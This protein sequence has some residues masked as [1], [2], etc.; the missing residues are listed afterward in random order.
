MGIPL[1]FNTIAKEYGD[2]V[3]NQ[4]PKN[5][6]GLYL[7]LNCAIHPCCRRVLDENYMPSNRL[8]YETKMLKEI[9]DYIIKLITITDPQLIFI[10]I[11][12]VAP[13]AK[14]KQQRSRRFKHVEPNT[15]DT[16]AISPGTP[17]MQKIK[18]SIDRL[19]SSHSIFND[20]KVI[21][22]DASIPG[23]GEHKIL[24]FIREKQP[25]GNNIIYG[26]D[27]DLIMLSMVSGLNNLFLLR[28]EVIHGITK[29]TFITVN[30]DELKSIIIMDFK[31]RVA[32]R[33]GEAIDK[34]QIIKD[35]VFIC[36]LL[37][38]D[39]LPHLLSLDLRYSGLKIIMDI[40]VETLLSIKEN[41]IVENKINKNFLQDF[42]YR[43]SLKE[44]SLVKNV[45]VKRLALNRNFR[46]RADTEEEKHK[47]LELNKP[48][49]EMEEEKKIIIDTPNCLDWR[50]RFY[51]HTHSK[52]VNE[53]CENYVEGLYWTAEYYFSGVKNWRWQYN[54]N[55]GPLLTD[56]VEWIRKNNEPNVNICNEPVSQTV[57]L[58][59]IF[60]S[61]SAELIDKKYRE[62]MTSLDSPILYMYPLNY[63][64]DTLFK[65]YNWLCQP[66]LPKIDITKI[67]DIIKI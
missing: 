38:N 49:L 15:W 42:I 34:S 59:S 29:E 53:L 32:E 28:E 54:H 5:I 37:G 12:G 22:S 20:K 9:S 63:K 10:A 17:F 61:R 6:N 3:D 39:F 52:N 67:E 60:P 1:F 26:L 47:Q 43:L 7:D 23:E 65:R 21:F 57:Q 13:L 40:Y 58:L 18:S 66:I 36:F 8:F 41:A 2:V 50:K 30:I 64:I 44:D 16:N 33:G 27:A 55:H 46:I 25:T 19:I 4:I 51:Y 45:F 48:I 62:L 24:S 14:M 35:Y 11:D 31:D 56:L